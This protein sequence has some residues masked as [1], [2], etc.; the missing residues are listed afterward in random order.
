F[1]RGSRAS[2]DSRPS[3]ARHR[4]SP[5]ARRI[6]SRSRVFLT[7]RATTSTSASLSSIR[8]AGLFRAGFVRRLGPP[9]ILV[10]LAV[11]RPLRAASVEVVLR[12]AYAQIGTTTR[13]D[14]AYR[15]LAYPGGDVPLDRGSCTDVLVRAY[16]RA[17]ID[18][19]LLVHE[20]MLLAFD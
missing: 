15:R 8:G 11:A 2:S 5:A 13:Y 16:R 6:R 7:R 12:G 18:L 4:R 3:E 19:Q 9:A 14:G 17:G 20:D 1:S 10:C